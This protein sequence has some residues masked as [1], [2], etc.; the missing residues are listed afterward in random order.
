MAPVLKGGRRRER[1]GIGRQWFR[2]RMV[3]D[4]VRGEEAKVALRSS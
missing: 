2:Q 4:V 1:C 3:K